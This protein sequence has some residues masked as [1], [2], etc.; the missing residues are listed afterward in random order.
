MKVSVNKK[1]K[2]IKGDTKKGRDEFAKNKE[3]NK[4]RERK[5]ER[6]RKR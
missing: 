6:K 5:R 2:T 4:N 3:T 1:K